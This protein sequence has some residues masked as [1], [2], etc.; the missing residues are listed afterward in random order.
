MTFDLLS[1]IKVK[2]TKEI[3]QSC[4]YRADQTETYVIILTMQ[5]NLIYVSEDLIRFE[6]HSENKMAAR[7]AI[8]YFCVI[9]PFL[10][11][12]PLEI[13]RNG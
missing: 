7:R 1:I 5:I 4:V 13:E 6:A 2:F 10:S 3:F 11:R 12:K 9:L 8:L